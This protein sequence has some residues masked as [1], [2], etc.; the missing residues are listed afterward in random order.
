MEN[1]VGRKMLFDALIKK[2]KSF[3]WE[4]DTAMLWSAWKVVIW[5]FI[6]AYTYDVGQAEEEAAKEE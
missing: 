4:G 3:G 5:P 1:T 2:A 6:Q